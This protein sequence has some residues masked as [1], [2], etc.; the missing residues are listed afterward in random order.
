MC[1]NTISMRTEDFRRR[2]RESWLDLFTL[3]TCIREPTV[4]VS[5]ADRLF[6]PSS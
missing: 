3:L 5:V 2:D 4:W 1:P 6:W